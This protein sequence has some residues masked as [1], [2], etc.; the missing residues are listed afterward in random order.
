MYGQFNNWLSSEVSS[1]AAPNLEDEMMR[2]KV[3]GA[4]SPCTA[5]AE[6]EMR[7][8]GAREGCEATRGVGGVL[9]RNNI[10]AVPK[11]N[12]GKTKMKGDKRHREQW[13]DVKTKK[14]CVEISQTWPLN[15]PWALNR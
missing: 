4:N 5:A 13:G 15:R 1:G 2:R 7:E 12:K 9:A 11:A 10:A 3:L 8:A 6:V 14:G